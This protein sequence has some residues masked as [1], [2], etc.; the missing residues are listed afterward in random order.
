MQYRVVN[1]W[2]CIDMAKITLTWQAF[3]NVLALLAQVSG[4]VFIVASIFQHVP[5][6]DKIEGNSD[7]AEH[8]QSAIKKIGLVKIMRAIMGNKKSADLSFYSA[9]Q[10]VQLALIARA[11]ANASDFSDDHDMQDEMNDLA[12]VY[13][14][15]HK[16]TGWKLIEKT[17]TNTSA[18]SP[19]SA[20]IKK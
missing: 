1:T 5:I 7:N 14:K 18:K 3:L 4:R 12:K 19:K 13:A 11:E 9:K 2:E 8:M 6:D 10:N 16:P 17:R 20:L 15:Y